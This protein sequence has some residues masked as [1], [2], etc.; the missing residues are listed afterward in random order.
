LPEIL[1]WAPGHAVQICGQNM[2]LE[3]KILLPNFQIFAI[4]FPKLFYGKNIV[5]LGIDNETLLRTN[6]GNGPQDENIANSP[7]RGEFNQQGNI[8]LL[9]DR[10]DLQAG[11]NG[12]ISLSYN[13]KEA[14]S[15]KENSGV[16][17]ANVT[18][19]DNRTDIQEGG[20]QKNSAAEGKRENGN[21]DGFL[22]QK[23]R[24]GRETHKETKGEGNSNYKRVK[25][26]AGK[27]DPA[28]KGAENYVLD[29]NSDSSNNNLYINKVQSTK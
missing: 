17:N 19:A 1:S 6:L 16:N 3:R 23:R 11:N 7:A 10:G 2:L 18:G 22:L 21:L 8:Q 14:S 27:T 26:N 13:K 24:P 29:S 9:N 25:T 15:N 4:Q 5:F 20:A 28:T 12:I